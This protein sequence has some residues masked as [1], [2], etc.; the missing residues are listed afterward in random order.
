M[1]CLVWG[2]ISLINRGSFI[3][4]HRVSFG[5]EIFWQ[6]LRLPIAKLGDVIC[7]FWCSFLCYFLRSLY[8]GLF[9]HLFCRLCR[10]V[11]Y[12]VFYD[13][14]YGKSSKLPWLRV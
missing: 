14:L 7:D 10:S 5:I 2:Y 12:S 1:S 3:H 4:I 8:S 11:L 6:L 13:L 9:D